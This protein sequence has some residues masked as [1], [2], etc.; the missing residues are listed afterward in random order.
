MRR[1]GA[2]AAPHI[3]KI[4]RY[5]ST[6]KVPDARNVGDQA[7]RDPVAP[8]VELAVNGLRGLRVGIFGSMIFVQDG[9]VKL[10]PILKSRNRF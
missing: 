1:A 6:A 8:L 3:A 4:V 9:K 5:W 10:R 7:L 2:Q